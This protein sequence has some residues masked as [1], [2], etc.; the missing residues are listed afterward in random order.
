MAATT[1]PPKVPDTLSNTPALRKSVAITCASMATVVLATLYQGWRTRQMLDA[2]TGGELPIALRIIL[3]L[4]F[5]CASVAALG[6]GIYG[7]AAVPVL[8]RA[9]QRA[10][11]RLLSAQALLWG[12]IGV[13]IVGLFGVAILG[14]IFNFLANLWPF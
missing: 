1:T 3:V 4:M 9:R 13:S 2:F 7:L 5:V 6:M 14:K 12:L 8:A 10:I 11:E